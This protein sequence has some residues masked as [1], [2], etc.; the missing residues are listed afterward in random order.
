MS[1]STREIVADAE[2]LAHRYDRTADTI[3]FVQVPRARHRAISFLTDDNIGK[4]PVKILSR[5]AALN[6]APSGTPHFIFHSGFCGSTM[7][8]RAM[9]HEGIA[10]GL[11]EPVLLN[12]I[13]GFRRRGA[14]Q[15]PEVARALGDAL[16]LLAR[17]F[18]AGEPVIIKP[19]NVLNTL[20]GA[21]L[22]IRPESKALFLYAPLPVF[23][24]SVARKGMWCRL[25][26]RELLEGLLQER[27]VNL[28]FQSSDYFRLT[29]LQVAAI[30]WLT[31]H[32]MFQALAQRIDASRLRTLDSETLMDDQGAAVS[33]LAAHFGFTPDEAGLLANNKALTRH[34]KTGSVFTPGARRAEQEQARAAYGDEIE[35]V[36]A[37]AEAVAKNAGVS[38][39]P[40]APLG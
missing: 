9:D 20:A 6:N 40:F 11:S 16:T 39:Q 7:L 28:G 3:H 25:W 10:M 38:M 33:A 32:S 2:W 17:P 34:S 15:P 27:A 18:S 24:T 30:G 21:M 37:W 14:F 19:S 12:D 23:L 1:L 31:Q 26:A 8:A 4:A 22:A 13:V 5:G 35:K 36:A 29:D